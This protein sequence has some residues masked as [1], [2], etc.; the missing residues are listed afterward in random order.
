MGPRVANVTKNAT[1]LG[2]NAVPKKL[3]PVWYPRK[4]FALDTNIIIT[5]TL[6]YLL[7]TLTASGQAT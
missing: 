5:V 7:C 1:G 3:H 2:P 4:G 6:H